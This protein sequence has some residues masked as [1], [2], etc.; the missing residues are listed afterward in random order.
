MPIE[1]IIGNHQEA[2]PIRESWL[3]ALESLAPEIIRQ[4]LVQAAAED[5]PLH[6]LAT[7]EVA[8]VDDKTSDRVHR[9][10][11]DIE[12]TTDVITFHHGEIVIGAEVA[13]RQAAEYKEPLGREFLRYLTHG[14]LH[15]AG[16]ED[17]LPEDR[18]EMEAI[19]ES[20]VSQLWESEMTNRLRS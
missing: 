3:C 6:H 7:L 15:L 14:I 12:G 1:V 10:F 4:A 9:E 5:S 19:Q 17:E 2:I 16:H 8:L 13:A 18:A 11:M 20:F